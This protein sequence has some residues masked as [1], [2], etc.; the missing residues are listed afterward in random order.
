MVL[1]TDRAKARAGKPSTARSVAGFPPERVLMAPGPSNLHPRVVQ[2]LSAPLTGHKDPAFLE[3]MVSVAGL[4]REVFQ[5]KNAATFALPAT[6]GSGME[7]SLM[8]LL[9]PGDAVVIGRGGFFANRMVGIAERIG[10]RVVVVDA[11]W[12]QPLDRDE[13]LDAVR[14]HRAKVLAV[15]H[16]ETSTGV[17]Q[18]LAGL[19]RACRELNAFLVVDAVAS[20][21]GTA[22]AVDDLA[23]DLCYSG[24]QKCLSAPPGLCPITL[25]PRAL[26]AIEERKA[27]VP[28][29]YFDLGLHA[30]Y[31][32]TEHI[33][34]HTA[35]VLNVYAL[36]EAL[37]IV[38]E[39]GLEG[40]FARHRLHAEALRAGLTALGVQLF[41]HAAHR[42]VPVVTALVPEGVSDA[43]TRN[44]LLDQYSIEIAGG[45]GDY[46]GRMWRV[47]VMGHSA[48]RSNVKLLLGAL[49]GILRAQG[50]RSGSAAAAADDVYAA[51]AS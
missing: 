46:A 33:Y 41:A 8:N 44:A 20:L 18:P 2:A 9:E 11:P 43:V 30:R 21:G 14:T 35:P 29:W 51:A 47:G 32:D 31:W 34:H 3:I 28:S 4:L 48:T 23:I 36:H 38:Q 49:E 1:S 24:S 37:R 19:G 45:L 7:A 26:A 42:L 50:Y 12:G 22:L 5:T 6:G 16:G 39:E 10:A 15:V 25:S 40:R 27:P 13:L 17:E